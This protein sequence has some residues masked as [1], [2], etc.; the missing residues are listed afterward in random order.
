VEDAVLRAAVDIVQKNRR[1]SSGQTKQLL[2]KIQKLTVIYKSSTL[3]IFS[4]R[5]FSAPGPPAR[6]DP[7]LVRS[8]RGSEGRAGIEHPVRLY[9]VTTFCKGT[10]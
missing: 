7:E 10:L 3:C 5:P 4:Y 6:P 9:C 1:I 8:A 2:H